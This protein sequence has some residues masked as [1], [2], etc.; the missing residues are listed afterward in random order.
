[1]G[2]LHKRMAVAHVPKVYYVEKREWYREEGK[3]ESIKQC[4]KAGE[5]M[6]SR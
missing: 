6:D 4:S 1:M 5:L 3:G 2:A